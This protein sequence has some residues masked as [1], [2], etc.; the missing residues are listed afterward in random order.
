MKKTATVILCL[1]LAAALALSLAACGE[2]KETVATKE[3]IPKKDPVSQFK[4]EGFDKSTL[5]NQVSWEGIN[6]F[7]T[8]TEISALY[9]T[10]ADAAIA[11]ARKST[12]D[13]FN[14]A[15]TATWIPA[16]TWEFYHSESSTETDVMTAGQVYG[17][18]PYVGM[19]ASAIYRLMD[20]IDEETGVVDIYKAAG[21]NHEY[22]KM[23]GNQCAQGAYQGWSRFIN[24]AKYQG[25]PSMT[26]RSNF[27]PVGS[28]TYDETTKRWSK[29]Y[30]TKA[31][32]A[33]ND[34][35]TVYE[36]YALMQ[37]GDGVVNF[38][39]A[40]HVMMI[41]SEPVVV[42]SADGT[43]DGTQSYVYRTDQ[44]V[45]FEN[46]TH[47]DGGD[48]CLAARFINKK[49]SFYSLKDSGYLPFTFKEW[50]GEDPIEAPEYKFEH[51]GDSI[52][53]EQLY[54]EKITSNYHIYD[55]YAEVYDAVGNEVLKIAT[56]ND[57][58]STYKMNFL[59][60]GDVHAV[61]WGSVE[62]LEAGGDYTVKIYMQSGTGE[63][64]DLWEGKLIVE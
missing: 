15:K 64:P 49:T 7:K 28:Y 17:G 41:V 61:Y 60:P 34:L 43:I 37:P 57:Y 6:Q 16:D 59:R 13:F 31:V 27:I 14:Y 33:E 20:F 50:L 32:V 25:T 46:Y 45:Q 63:R 38:T 62:D 9:K 36:S 4:A 24:S 51:Q 12:V 53:L 3:P 26:L 22:Q 54:T 1:L 29:A 23:F 39:T 56:H 11:E 42:R 30:N 40:G 8:A 2:K 44:H 35:Q 48:Q 47:P 52:T 55:I 21:E 10:D 19:A 58:A 5:K 18:L